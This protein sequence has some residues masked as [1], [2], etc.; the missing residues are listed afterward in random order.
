M[1]EIKIVIGAASCEV[2][3]YIKEMVTSSHLEKQISVIKT[4]LSP[5]SFSDN[6]FD[7]LLCRGAFFYFDSE[8]IFLKE[9]FR[10][11][12]KGGVGIIGGGYGEKTPKSLID[13][14]K[15]E[16]RKLNFMIG[17]RWFSREEVEEILL[18][19]N[20]KENCY[21]KEKGGLWLVIE[22]TF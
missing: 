3:E 10:I 5:I 18:R 19:A 12:K 13:E 7:L 17:R 16:S 22:K 14:I 20:L 9:I 2:T 1:P 6:Q 8:G 15:E 11:L 4:S 21:I